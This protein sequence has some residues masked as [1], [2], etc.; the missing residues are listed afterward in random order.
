MQHV[1]P[2]MAAFMQSL[3]WLR[4]WRLETACLPMLDRAGSGTVIDQT[5]MTGH[6]THS[7][8]E[9]PLE[10]RTILTAILFHAIRWV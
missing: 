10:R 8:R 7:G 3:L 6:A 5:L 9:A 1:L 4:G 2:Y